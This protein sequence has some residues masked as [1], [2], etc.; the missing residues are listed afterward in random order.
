[1]KKNVFIVALAI[2]G[3]VQLGFASG[4]TGGNGLTTAGD[5]GNEIAI[6][7]DTVGGAGNGLVLK[8]GGRNG[9]AEGS[10]INTC[11]LKHRGGNGLVDEDKLILR[12]KA[13]NGFAKGH[14]VGNG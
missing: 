8:H 14:R 2:L 9:L 11:I 13:G 7:K 1:M 3:M 5:K 4:H 10:R 6:T 12:H